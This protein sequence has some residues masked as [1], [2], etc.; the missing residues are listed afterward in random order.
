MTTPITHCKHGHKFTVENTLWQR[1]HTHR[2]CRTCKRA[3]ENRRAPRYRDRKY[4]T[5]RVRRKRH[6]KEIAI[7]DKR[8][9]VKRAYGLTLE[10]FYSKLKSQENLCALCKLPFEGSGKQKL[11]PAL[12]HDHRNGKI[13]E[14]IHSRCNKAIGM[15]E[16]SSELLRLA[17]AYLEKHQ[18]IKNVPEQN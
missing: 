7:I 18:E 11:A 14:F 2:V 12:D 1:K 9:R 15:L 3:G 8:S 13:R 16:D 17:V 10:E 4:R 5:K 6:P